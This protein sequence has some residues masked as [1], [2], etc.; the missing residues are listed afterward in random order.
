MPPKAVPKQKIN[1][2]VRQLVWDTYNGPDCGR[3]PCFTGCG[4]ELRQSHFEC[5]HIIPEANGGLATVENLR[6]ICES[7]NKNMG[8]L[9][10]LR[11]MHRLLIAKGDAGAIAREQA[12]RANP[13]DTSLRVWADGV[14]ARRVPSAEEALAGL[15]IM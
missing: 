13:S 9:D 1:K 11:F 12:H 3:A 8:T 7:C 6:P 15:R 14:R 10:M 4:T 5:G 2:T